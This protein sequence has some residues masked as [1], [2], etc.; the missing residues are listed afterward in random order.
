M[1]LIVAVVLGVA[2]VVLGFPGADEIDCGPFGGLQLVPEFRAP[3]DDFGYGVTER[4]VAQRCSCV[5]RFCDGDEQSEG[6]GF[7]GHHFDEWYVKE[8]GNGLEMWLNNSGVLWVYTVLQD[9]WSGVTRAFKWFKRADLGARN[10][11]CESRAGTQ[12]PTL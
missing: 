3:A 12:L 1:S 8:K 9:G 2:A 5:L 10:L 4:H 11:G 7:E 6:E